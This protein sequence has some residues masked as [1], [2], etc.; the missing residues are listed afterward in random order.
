MEIFELIARSQQADLDQ[1]AARLKANADREKALQLQRAS[2]GE[3][4]ISEL[5]KKLSGSDEDMSPA[6]QIMSTP[7]VS[8]HDPINTKPQFPAPPKGPIEQKP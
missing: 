3:M 7:E 6:M 8:I 4:N 1:E 2:K 5:L